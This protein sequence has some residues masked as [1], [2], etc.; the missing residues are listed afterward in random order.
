MAADAVLLAAALMLIAPMPASA[1]LG[2]TR[3]DYVQ[4]VGRAGGPTMTPGQVSFV[5]PHGTSVIVRF[6]DGHSR[7][8]LWALG[9]GTAGI[10]PTLLEQ[11]QTLVK[12]TPARRVTFRLSKA[13]PAEVFEQRTGDVTI[14]VDRRGERIVRIVQCNAPPCVL[15]DQWLGMERA[16][17][18]LLA[19]SEQQ[20]Q[21]QRK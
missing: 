7:E 19:R 16:T 8:E 2:W 17:D 1:E 12:G 10:P 9:P 13:V 15:L 3:D 18:D 6:A 14:Q 21:R 4:H 20:L 5:A 11:A